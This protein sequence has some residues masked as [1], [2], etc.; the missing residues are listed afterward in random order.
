MGRRRADEIAVVRQNDV[1]DQFLWQHRLYQVRE[2]LAYWVEA[3]RWWAAG[4]AAAMTSGEGSGLSGSSGSGSSGS[5]SS[6]SVLTLD[7]GEREFWR[8]EAAAGRSGQP[9]I[10]DL[11][12]DWAQ[13][14]W[15][16]VQ[17]MD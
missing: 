9:G 11:S 1:P 15:Q 2:V 13:A 5:V 3:G 14:R 16:L 17:V 8:V 4:A 10:F 6:G 7:D 12:F